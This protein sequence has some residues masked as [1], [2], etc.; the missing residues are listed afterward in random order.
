ME[1]TLAFA[2]AARFTPPVVSQPWWQ[3]FFDTE[4]MQVWGGVNPPEQTVR[5]ADALWSLLELRP[6][7][8]V[9]DAMCGYGRLSQPLAERGA[10]LVGVDS[11]GVLLA[12]AERERGEVRPQRLSYV[13]ADLREPISG[14]EPFDAAFNVFSSL[15]YGSEAEDVAILHNIGTLLTAGAPLFIDTVHRDMVTA[16][17]SRGTVPGRRLPD[18]TLLVEKTEFDQLTGRMHTTWYWYG[19]RGEGTKSASLRIYSP[20]ELCALASRAGLRVERA[21]RGISLTPFEGGGEDMG[22]RLGLIVRKL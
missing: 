7:M 12:H 17:L 9:L 10:T 19:P 6:G 18:G 22:G 13:H 16:R 1:T 15:G 3:S 20:T 5:E 14:L 8:R 4:Y 2:A 11:S 21:V